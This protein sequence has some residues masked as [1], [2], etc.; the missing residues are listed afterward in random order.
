MFTTWY[1][2]LSQRL[3]DMKV[4]LAAAGVILRNTPPQ[5][6]IEAVIIAV[7]VSLANVLLTVPTLRADID[8]IRRER[9]IL[10]AKRS[11]QVT[12]IK[13]EAK[14]ARQQREQHDREVLQRLQS[15]ESML[16]EI[17]IEHARLKR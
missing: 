9:E 7:L 11:E 6:Y 16:N 1:T 8:G 17:K 2:E 5:R 3:L 12:E 15:I 4:G 13:I 10:V 14:E